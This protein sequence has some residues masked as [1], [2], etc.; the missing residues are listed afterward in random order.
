VRAWHEGIPG[1][2]ALAR[3]VCKAKARRR[4]GN[5]NQMIARRALDLASG[6]LHFTLQMLLAMGAL[7]FEFVLSHAVKKVN[8]NRRLKN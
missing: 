5:V 8:E 4:T 1:L 6:K 2:A 3:D 7:K